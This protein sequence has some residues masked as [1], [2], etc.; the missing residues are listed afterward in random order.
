MGTTGLCVHP[1]DGRPHSQNTL[2]K[3]EPAI[4]SSKLEDKSNVL[5]R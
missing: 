2:L 4:E 1:T 5:D 3:E